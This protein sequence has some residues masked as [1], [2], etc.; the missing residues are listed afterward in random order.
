[1]TTST[2]QRRWA[3][4]REATADEKTTTLRNS[5]IG[6][7]AAVHATF[8]AFILGIY[9]AA[10]IEMTGEPF[11]DLGVT[12]GRELILHEVYGYWIVATVGLGLV[13][14][15][16]YAYGHRRWNA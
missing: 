2:T 1:M 10:Q 9:T 3:T 8:V 13:F 5:L 4:P 15:A 16:A 7:Y 6:V 12:L 11:N 14:A